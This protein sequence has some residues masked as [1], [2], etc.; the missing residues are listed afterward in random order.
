MAFER[1][2]I[3]FQLK[4]NCLVLIVNL[5]CKMTR[6]NCKDGAHYNWRWG[7]VF[8]WYLYVLI[9]HVCKQPALPVENRGVCS[10]V[11]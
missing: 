8:S 9:A 6:T 3:H 1:N 7:L 2:E 11:S 4:N 5:K 10:Q